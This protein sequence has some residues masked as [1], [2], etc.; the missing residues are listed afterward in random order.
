MLHVSLKRLAALCTLGALLNGSVTLPLEARPAVHDGPPATN[1][2]SAQSPLNGLE[3]IENGIIKVGVDSR[4]GGAISYLAPIGGQNMVNNFDPGRQFQISNYSGPA[5]YSQNGNAMW[6]SIGWNPI[7]GGDWAG[8]PAEVVA[9]Q[10]Q[11]N[12]IYVKTI[13]KQF[14]LNNVPGEVYIEHWIRLSGNV[15]KVHAKLTLFR[16]DRTQYDARSQEHPCLF[17]NPAY[18]NVYMYQG[19]SPYT[20]GA[21]TR[22]VAPTEQ[23]YVRPVTEP[24]MAAT[25]N[26]GFGVGLFKRNNYQWTKGFFGDNFNSGEFGFSSTYVA[27]SDFVVLDHN[28]VHEW[29]YDLIVGSIDQIRNYVY[30]QP[31]LGAT[32][33]YRFDDQTRKGWYYHK[34][35]DTGWPIQN[36]LHVMVSNKSE[37]AIK[38]PAGFWRGRDNKIIY[39]RAAFQGQSDTYR[40]IWRQLNDREFI[41]TPDRYIDFPII[42]DGQFHTYAIDLSK[43]SSWTDQEIVQFMFGPRYDGPDVNG[44]VKIESVTTDPNATPVA[45]TPPPTYTSPTPTPT[46]PVTSTTGLQ[47]LP[48]AYDCNTGA[49]TFKTSGGNGSTIEYMA[50]GITG[51]TT[52]PNHIVDAAIRQDPMTTT[53]NLQA[54]QSGV[55]VS[56]AFPFKA[57][58][59]GTAIATPI[60]VSPTPT[61]PSGTGLQLVAPGYNC[62]TGALTFKTTGGNGS[63]IEY[64]AV[65]V[66]GWTTNPNQ[67]VDAGIR[68]DPT[69]KTLTLQARQNG[70]TVS[71]T[72]DFRAYCAGGT[73]TAP[74]TTTMA[75]SITSSTGLQLLAPAYDCNTG[76]LTFKTSGGNG[77]TIEY[78]AMGITGWTTNPNHIVD[79]ALRQDP[80]TTMLTLQARQSGVAISYSFP[81]KAYCSGT[82]TTTSPTV[83]TSPV[84]GLSPTT[85]STSTSQLFQLIMPAYN[86]QTGQITFRTSGGNGS[87]I[88]YMAIGVTGWTTN[89]VQTVDLGLRLD[90]GSKPLSLQARQNGVTVS[91]TFDFRAYCANTAA[92]VASSEETP[93]TISVWGNPV[94]DQLVVVV[95]GYTGETLDFRIVNYNGDVVATRTLTGNDRP[96]QH[97]FD[98]SG[99]DAGVLV[100]QVSDGTRATS[101]KIIKQ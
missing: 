38:S 4:Y 63:T 56:Y 88:E 15:V 50:L 44:W 9:F 69:A 54:R 47:L 17:I 24:W 19:N 79:A 21:M 29:D 41:P 65:G 93:L 32:I 95:E 34:A 51:W 70:I 23:E 1:T 76:A 36:N 11:A 22:I 87:T 37:A 60:T 97:V 64:M 91:Y 62:N 85:G 8:N 46:E 67:I 83:S 73:T 89:P 72:F 49:L 18:N 40:M 45:T 78:M 81:F 55:A 75:A 66:T 84:G 94:V 82:L 74:L 20:N 3:T 35:Q 7:Q 25:N 58:C 77:S 10:K 27:A 14:A 33:N 2:T 12:E 53:L 68:Q 96:G 30:S 100:M 90:P 31:R 43:R 92:R 86:C 57:Y 71:Y 59:S 28:I 39:L 5:N 48:P 98:L 26:S 52:N 61:A 101:T 13:G 16:S 42:N 80:M 99:Q 6:S